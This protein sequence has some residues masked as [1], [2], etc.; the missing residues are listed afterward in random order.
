METADSGK[1][2]EWYLRWTWTGGKE[3]EEEEEEG[4]GLEVIV[5]KYERRAGAC[6]ELLRVEALQA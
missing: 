1:G 4:V 2:G 3:E 6:D 5:V